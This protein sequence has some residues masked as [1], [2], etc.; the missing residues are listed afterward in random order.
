MLTEKED[1]FIT[2]WEAN[3]ELQKKGFRQYVKGLSRGLAIGAAIILL[4][5][6][7]WY[8]RADMEV[9]SKLSTGVF[10]LAIV[11]IAVFM[12]WLY[13]NYQWEMQEQQYLELLAKK[14]KEQANANGG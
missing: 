4:V 2:Y 3:R 13:H 11:I 7:G 5:V 14:R 6:A 12:A 8:E 1:K 9:N 10:I